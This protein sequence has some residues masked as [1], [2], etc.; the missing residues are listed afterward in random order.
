MDWNDDIIRISKQAQE[1][2]NLEQAVSDIIKKLTDKKAELETEITTTAEM[3]IEDA[4]DVQR[5][6]SNESENIKRKCDDL[7]GYFDSLSDIERS[8]RLI[9][10]SDMNDTEGLMMEIKDAQG[11]LDIINKYSKK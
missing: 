8:I 11:T 3:I 7:E 10:E 9:T 2:M 1:D 4:S 6:M 5:K